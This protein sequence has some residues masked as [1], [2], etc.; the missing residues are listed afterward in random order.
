MA[1]SASVNR[2]VS[3]NGRWSSMFSTSAAVQIP[4]A[5]VQQLAMLPHRETPHR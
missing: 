4:E 3:L 2:S 5:D 1:K